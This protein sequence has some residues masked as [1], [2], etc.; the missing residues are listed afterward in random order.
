MI[1]P[2]KHTHPKNAM[3]VLFIASLGFLTSFCTGA[4]LLIGLLS[5]YG[6][7]KIYPGVHINGI[8]VGDLSPVDAQV[9]LSSLTS[10]S[11]TGKIVLIDGSTNWLS[12]PEQLGYQVDIRASITQAY[13]YGRNGFWLTNLI[14]RIDLRMNPKNFPLVLVNDQTR[15]QQFV[16]EI[17][18][19]VHKPVQE[20]S[21]QLNGTD[22]SAVPGQIGREVDIPSTLAAIQE[23][24]LHQQ[25]A[26][27]P[28][29]I[30]ETQPKIMDLSSQADA[31]RKIIAEPLIITMPSGSA[32]DLGPWAIGREDLAKM[33]VFSQVDQDGQP[34]IAIQIN[35]DLLGAFLQNLTPVITQA[36]LNARFIFNDETGQLDVLEH[37]QIGREVD[38]VKSL[39]DATQ[40]ILKGEHAM[41][42]TVNEVIPK[43]TDTTLG[44]DLGITELVHQ[45]TSYFYG[46]NASRVN[47]I[48]TAAGRFHGLLVAPGAI[49]SMSDVIGDISLDSGFSEAL[50]IFGNETIKGVGGGVCQVSTTLFRAAFFTG[51]PILERY[52]HAYRVGYYEQTAYGSNDPNLAGLDATVFVPVVDMKFRNDTPYWLLME[53]WIKD[54]SLTWKFYST[55]D[56]R[57]VEWDTTGPEN[58]VKAPKMKYVENQD[59][60]EGK[61]K[62][63][64]WSAEGADITVQRTVNKDGQVYF[65]DSFYTHYQPWQA[66]CQYGPGTNLPKKGD[67]CGN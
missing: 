15:A 41:N 22:V 54:Y 11:S 3:T 40:T 27:I 2:S 20:A 42:L 47:N 52:A 23:Q 31:V 38:F 9:K 39:A 1:Y 36:A 44:K 24:L 61:M 37:S 7:G 25:D 62:Q 45:E 14:Q 65:T 49:L 60:A 8:D 35:Q 12:T 50:I 32:S 64:D 55:A 66:I 16:M 53:T 17:S 46:S 30:I 51:Y 19:Q 33:L 6:D 67:R 28:V 59:L 57:S 18:N 58:I 29:V 56:G 21:I 13:L 26:I 4:I 43:A 10:Y 34:Q 5:G 48:K 63:V